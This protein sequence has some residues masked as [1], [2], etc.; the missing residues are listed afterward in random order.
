MPYEWMLERDL[1]D[2]K[3]HAAVLTYIEEATSIANTS[4]TGFG[5]GYD[6]RSWMTPPDGVISTI[7]GEGETDG[8]FGAIYTTLDYQQKFESKGSSYDLKA[9]RYVGWP[10]LSQDK[11]AAF[12]SSAE[13]ALVDDMMSLLESVEDEKERQAIWERLKGCT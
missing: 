4:E 9:S 2:P 6:Y 12:L 11:A 7:E 3:L 5:I 13:Q 8:N 1:P 10:A